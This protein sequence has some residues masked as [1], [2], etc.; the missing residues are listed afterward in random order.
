[1]NDSP[2]QFKINSIS[3]WRG[4]IKGSFLKWFHCNLKLS[5]FKN[6]VNSDLK[7]NVAKV[8]K[9]A[10]KRSDLK[11]QQLAIFAISRMSTFWHLFP[12]KIEK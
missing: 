7:T 11:Q 4:F 12:P 10:L 5:F 3:I 9:K 8:S 2:Q 6:F 1:M